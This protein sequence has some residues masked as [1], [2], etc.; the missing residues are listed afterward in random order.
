MPEKQ[1]AASPTT[2]FTT[3]GESPRKS[4][5]LILVP[6]PQAARVRSAVDNSNWEWYM[7]SSLKEALE[8]LLSCQ[9]QKIIALLN[10]EGF[11]LARTAL[12]Y[13]S[14]RKPEVILLEG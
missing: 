8:Q 13:F 3:A 10:E 1:I 6:E 2:R 4:T 14:D 7:A 9:P 12:T 5:G 11:E